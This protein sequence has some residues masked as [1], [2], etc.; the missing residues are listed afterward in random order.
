MSARWLRL[1]ARLAPG[2]RMA[3][4]LPL[5]LAVGV[6]CR[7]SA[8]AGGQRVIVL[9]FDGMDHALVEAADRR[10]AAAELRP[11]RRRGQLRSRSAPSMPPQSPVAWSNFITGLDAGG[12]GIFDFVHRDPK[13]MIPYLSTSRAE[14]AEKTL[15]LGKY[16]IPLG[17]GKV[18]L[19]RHGP[20]VL[21]GA[22]DARHRDHHHAHAGQLPALR[23]RPSAELSGMGTPDILGTYGTFSFYTTGAVSASPARTSSGGKVYAARRRSTTWP[24]PSSTGPPTPSWSSAR[25]WRPPSPLYLDPDEPV[26]KLVVGERG[27]RPQGRASGRDWVPVDVRPRRRPRT[28]PCIAR[29]YLKQVRPELRSCT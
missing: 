23:A 15:K 25:R 26:A 19:L 12:H 3:A 18:E 6:A 29:F 11:P 27:A 13:T 17:G 10:G 4:L 9:G 22:R 5:A 7:G 8:A 16:Q 24:R 2:L 1:R 28:C 14:A 20:A 21:G